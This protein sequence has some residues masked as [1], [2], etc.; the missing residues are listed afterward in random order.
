VGEKAV[1]IKR[2]VTLRMEKWKVL[3]IAATKIE[4][5]IRIETVP[6]ITNNQK[7]VY[8]LKVL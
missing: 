2:V 4:Q 3:Q 8:E 6:I 1:R 7:F 5:L